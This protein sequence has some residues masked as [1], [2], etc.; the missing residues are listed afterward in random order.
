V[1]AKAVLFLFT[2]NCTECDESIEDN[3]NILANDDDCLM[4]AGG[5]Y[6]LITQRIKDWDVYA[7]GNKNL[8]QEFVMF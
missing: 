8:H 3:T 7:S 6:W 4:K 2:G 5:V 1:H